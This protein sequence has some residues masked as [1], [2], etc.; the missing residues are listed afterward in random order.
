MKQF[1][2]KVLLLELYSQEYEFAEKSAVAFNA[3]FNGLT[4]ENYAS[5]NTLE[6]RIQIA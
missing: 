5:Y 3:I 6:E 2:I 4:Y 1:F